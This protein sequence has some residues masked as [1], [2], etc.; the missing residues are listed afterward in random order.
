[1]TCYI[2]VTLCCDDDDNKKKG[3]LVL[4]SFFSESFCLRNVQF[5]LAPSPARINKQ[6]T[7]QKRGINKKKANI[8]SKDKNHQKPTK[9]RKTKKRGSGS[10]NHI[11][12]RFSCFLSNFPPSFPLDFLFPIPGNKSTKTQWNSLH[13]F[14]LCFPCF[15]V[16]SNSLMVS[17]IFF[18][19]STWIDGNNREHKNNAF[20]N[21]NTE[22]PPILPPKQTKTP[23]IQNL[24]TRSKNIDKKPPRQ[25]NTLENKNSE[26]RNTN[27]EQKQPKPKHR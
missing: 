17:H 9:T 5:R 7:I 23:S 19:P 6:K 16:L 11:S 25:K 26:Q 4:F 20:P 1:M 3:N 15:Y 24:R 14:P 21:Q 13:L 27:L 18:L 12:P 8:S 10:K 2:G 22:K